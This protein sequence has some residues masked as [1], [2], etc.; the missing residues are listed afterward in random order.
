MIVVCPNCSCRYSVQADAI[1]KEKIVRCAMCGTTWQQSANEKY[2]EKRERVSDLIKW[3]FFGFVVFFTV[4]SLFFAKN[5]AIKIWP[6]VIDF[7]EL[8]G[9]KNDSSKKVFVLQNISNFFIMKK[10][11]LYMGLKG[12]LVNISNEVRVLPRIT[13]SL[14]DDESTAK[15]SKYKK[16]WTHNMTYKKLLPNQR[17]AFETE[18]QSV[19]YNNLICDIK[20]DTL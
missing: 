9:I 14:K 20:L 1:G 8:V 11:V 3:S 2:L 10:D 19:P 7:Y 17:V 16:I 13:V 5:F 6:P 12:E 4:F 18:M 15:D